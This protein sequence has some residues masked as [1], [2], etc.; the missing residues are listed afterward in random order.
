M[1][2]GARIV[3]RGP[4]PVRDAANARTPRD[5]PPFVLERGDADAEDHVVGGA[6][7][8]YPNTSRNTHPTTAS[9]IGSSVRPTENT[10]P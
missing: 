3:L 8:S 9:G 4:V 7:D 6:A 2:T 5:P 1:I 10:N